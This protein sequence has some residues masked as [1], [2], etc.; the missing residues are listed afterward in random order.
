MTTENG[1]IQFVF[2]NTEHN[3]GTLDWKE[4]SHCLDGIAIYTPEYTGSFGGFEKV[5][6]NAIRFWISITT[7]N[8]NDFLWQF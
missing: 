6:S 3:V 7:M 2:N 8:W 4:T 5:T 1:F